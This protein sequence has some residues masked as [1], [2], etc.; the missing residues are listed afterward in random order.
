M[1]YLLGID[2][3]T[4]QTTAVIVTELGEMV[5]KNSA[6]LPARFPKAG[7]VEQN[8]LD[9]LRTVKEACLPLLDKYEVTAAGFDNQGETFILWDKDTGEPVTPA[10]VWQDTRGESV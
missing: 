4:T 7:W 6:Q 5:E 1:K 3:G 2:Q 10:I 8:P 9:I